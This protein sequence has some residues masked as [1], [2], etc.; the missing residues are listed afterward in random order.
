VVPGAIGISESQLPKGRT[1]VIVSLALIAGL[2]L[3]M[4]LIDQTPN[5]FLFT[6]NDFELDI[7]N[8]LTMLGVWFL[9]I[10][11]LIAFIALFVSGL[12][13]KSIAG[14]DEL[15]G[16]RRCSVVLFLPDESPPGF[17]SLPLLI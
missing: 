2:A 1:F 16:Y 6:G 17:N 14:P 7:L 13:R 11:R 4:P 15:P 12:A 3:S 9:L 8:V 5:D 10:V